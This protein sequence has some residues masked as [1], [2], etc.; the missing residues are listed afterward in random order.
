MRQFEY[1]AV[2][3]PTTGTK[4]KG[5]KTR[6]DRFALS[7]TDI[8]NDH[9]DEGW[10]YVRAEMLPM[11]E[12]KGLTGTQTSYQNV[13][14]FRRLQS[15]PL[16]LDDGPRVRSVPAPTFDEPAPAKADPETRKPLST[17]A[18]DTNAPQLGAATD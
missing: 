15:A 6:E 18:D 9:A 8:L 11:E 1:M 12:R 17:T 4:A 7:M 2:P 10:E 3:A 14:I 5:V 16:A 13:L